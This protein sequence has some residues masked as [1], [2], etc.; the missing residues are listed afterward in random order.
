MAQARYQLLPN[1]PLDDTDVIVLPVPYEQTVSYKPGTGRGPEAILAATEQLEYYDEDQRWSP[2]KHMGITVLPPFNK[3]SAESEGDFQR[4]LQQGVAALPGR[5]LLL[6]LGGEHSITPALIQGRMSASGTAVLL[7]AHADLRRE[8][9]GTRFSHACPMHHVREAGH[10]ILM[11][12]VRSLLDEEAIRIDDDPGIRCFMDRELQR[13]ECWRALLAAI[14]ALSGP[15]WLTIDMDAFN[16]AVVPGVGT[17]QPGGLSW[18][19]VLAIIEACLFN[20]RV[21]LCG[22]DLVELVPE[23]S[24][25]SDMT[26]AKLSHKLISWWGKSQRLDERPER[27]S[28]T[29]IDYQ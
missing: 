12:G 11:A 16:P 3:H 20:P 24:C 13:P 10:T 1:R 4:R 9:D 29:E 22:C 8:F 26:A 14:A 6:A 7:D 15:V 17:P 21:S 23:P 25:V 28:Q 2:F 19:Q 18:Y 5:P 27:G